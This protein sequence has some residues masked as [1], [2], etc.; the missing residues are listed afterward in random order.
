MQQA[1]SE[2]DSRLKKL[3]NG[4]EK[5]KPRRKKYAKLDQSIMAAQIEFQVFLKII[6]QPVF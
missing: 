4:N 3:L 5:V 1:T 6:Y 2:K